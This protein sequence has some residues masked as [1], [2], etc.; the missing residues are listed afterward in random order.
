M[1][2]WAS[3]PNPKRQRGRLLCLRHVGPSLALWAGIREQG[4]GG[5]LGLK[6][7]DTSPKRERG[8]LLSLL[9]S[10]PHFALASAELCALTQIPRHGLGSAVS[11]AGRDAPAGAGF[12]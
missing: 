7:A 3:H 9:P 1:G 11:G 12:S 2:I 6:E 8:R 10:S 4:E 5:G